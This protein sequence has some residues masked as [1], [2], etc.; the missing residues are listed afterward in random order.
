M[1]M[2]SSSFGLK[3][4]FYMIDGLTSTLPSE[5]RASTWYTY[6]L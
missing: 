5:E 6:G 4:A 1:K 3:V 2:K